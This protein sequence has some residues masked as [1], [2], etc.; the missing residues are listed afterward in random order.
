MANLHYSTAGEF[1]GV[2]PQGLNTRRN[3]RNAA[4]W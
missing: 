3:A 4:G 1:G 2:Q